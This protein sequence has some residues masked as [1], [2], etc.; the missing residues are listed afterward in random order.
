MSHAVCGAI[1]VDHNRGYFF[2]KD[3]EHLKQHLASAT[4]FQLFRKQQSRSHWQNEVI[5][6]PT[7]NVMVSGLENVVRR[8]ESGR[9]KSKESQSIQNFSYLP[10]A[11]F[12]CFPMA[13]WRCGMR[14]AAYR[15]WCADGDTLC[16]VRIR[17]KALNSAHDGMLS[18]SLSERSPFFPHSLRRSAS[19]SRSFRC[20]HFMTIDSGGISALFVFVDDTTLSTAEHMPATEKQ[21]TRNQDLLSLHNIVSNAWQ[22]N[23]FAACFCIHQI[24]KI[25]AICGTSGAGQYIYYI[26][27]AVILDRNGWCSFWPGMGQRN[28]VNRNGKKEIKWICNG[29]DTNKNAS[30]IATCAGDIFSI[31]AFS[32]AFVSSFYYRW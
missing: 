6:V 17:I 1:L 16:V 28:S 30:S 32:K 13:R 29:H 23:Y 20:S 24:S 15:Y 4:E 5:F 31:R 7:E 9:V 22:N 12:R 21:N 27:S 26:R 10:Y 8:S 11:P 18:C 25:V 19:L 14:R 2:F 3:R